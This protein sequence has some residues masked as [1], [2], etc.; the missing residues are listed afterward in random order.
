[1]TISYD[2]IGTGEPLVLV[3][4]TGSSRKVWAPVLDA[5]A[6]ERDVI[7]V[8]LPGHGQSPLVPE[9]P[10]TPIGYARVV[11]ALLDE[12]GIAKAH[13]VGNSVGGWTALELAKLGRASSVV[14]L[15]PAGLWVKNPPRARVSL[16]MSHAA[17]P[18]MARVG[19][20]VFRP[21]PLRAALL[22]Q[23]FGRPTR[24]PVAD[25][26]ESA[27]GMANT[28]GFNDH[29]KQTSQSRFE[30]GA[31]IDVPVTVAYG[32]RER[33]IPKSA[34]MRDELPEQT[35]WVELE[36]CGHVPTWDDPWLVT[37]TIL[38]GSAPA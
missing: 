26:V 13:A 7:N 38:D 17:S 14:A 23:M 4:G 24:V 22:G 32:T 28:R 34:R 36:G 15:A 30:G 25:A 3:H 9:Q 29:L 6:A 19:P 20:V 10:P 27:R 16:R 8:D 33:L 31:S 1:M 2:R 12:L 35:R 37:R 21:A 11:A 5:L 18:L